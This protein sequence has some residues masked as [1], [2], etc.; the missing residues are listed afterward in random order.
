MDID[1][2]AIDS[3]EGSQGVSRDLGSKE[4]E[5]EVEKFLSSWIGATPTFWMIF[6]NSS[7]Q[8]NFALWICVKSLLHLTTFPKHD[9]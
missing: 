9:R 8:V 7:S 2:V 4:M 6:T 3:Y 1:K 5:K